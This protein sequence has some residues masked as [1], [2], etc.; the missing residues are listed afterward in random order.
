MMDLFYF[1]LDAGVANNKVSYLNLLKTNFKFLIS[2][3]SCGEWFESRFVG[4][5]EDRFC[6]VMQF[7]LS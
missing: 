5:P 4:N 3:C 6:T 7:V 1:G 2:L